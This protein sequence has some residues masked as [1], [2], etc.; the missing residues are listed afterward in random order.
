MGS[1]GGACSRFQRVGQEQ[2]RPEVLARL[3][4]GAEIRA[5][6]RGQELRAPQPHPHPVFRRPGAL[7]R[8]T[9]LAG[10]GRHQAHP[11]LD[12]IRLAPRS[13]RVAE[14][15]RDFLGYPHHLF[16]LGMGHSAGV[17]AWRPASRSS[18]AGDP[19]VHD[20]FRDTLSR[21]P[22]RRGRAGPVGGGGPAIEGGPPADGPSARARL[23]S[24][25]GRLTSGWHPV[26]DGAPSCREAT[27][28]RLLQEPVP[29]GDLLQG[30]P[31]SPLVVLPGDHHPKVNRSREASCGL[32]G[33]C[34]PPPQASVNRRVS[35]GRARLLPPQKDPFRTSPQLGSAH[36]SRF[37]TS[38]ACFSMNSR[39]G[40]T[41]SPMRVANRSLAAAAS[42]SRTW[43]KV[44]RDGSMVV[45]QS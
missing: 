22:P 29:S 6:A 38:S 11:A 42:S 28:G 39:R 24:D 23:K 13:D 14:I 16:P 12:E 26:G 5:G 43:S 15:P 35:P 32:Q 17:V 33:G 36:T 21:H 1:T 10:T 8:A 44:R 37:L 40:S 2:R 27:P 19:F 30:S 7:R 45:S 41:S 4:L 18:P 3:P 9:T 25:P 31:R 20:F 34:N